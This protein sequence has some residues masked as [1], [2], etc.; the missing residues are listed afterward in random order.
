MGIQSDCSH[1]QNRLHDVVLM[2]DQQGVALFET[3]AIKYYGG[4]GKFSGLQ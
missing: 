4:L 3:L 2:S 1:Y